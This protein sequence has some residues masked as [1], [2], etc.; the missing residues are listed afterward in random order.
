MPLISR[1]LNCLAGTATIVQDFTD[2][3]RKLE[4][5]HVVGL[6]GSHY[7]LMGQSESRSANG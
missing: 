6:P 2:V 3:N 1:G 5:I 4:D 7:G